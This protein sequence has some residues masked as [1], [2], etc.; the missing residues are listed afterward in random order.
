VLFD[1]GHPAH[2]H[3]FK[4]F[5]GWLQCHKHKVGIGIQKKDVLACLLEH[6]GYKYSV[7][8]VPRERRS[9]WDLFSQWLEHTKAL[10]ALAKEFRPNLLVGTSVAINW[11]G[12]KHKAGSWN[13]QEDDARVIKDY[14]A[15]ASPFVT[16]K[17]KPACL[18]F[19]KGPHDVYHPSYHELAY[20]HPGNFSPDKNILV[21]YGLREKEYVVV[22]FCALRAHH[23][24]Q[25]QGISGALR[26][27]IIKMMGCYTIV[28][29]VENGK[30]HRIEPWDMHH[31][32]AYAKM[33]IADSQ[34][35]TIEGA[36]LGVP[37]VRINT[38]IGKSTV[39]S[40][41]EDTYQLAI[42]ILPSEDDK[43]IEKIEELLNDGS[44]AAKWKT[45]RAR[46]LSEKV[47]LN[48]WMIDFFNG[49]TD[50]TSAHHRS[51]GE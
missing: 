10:H 28:E 3:L 46:L 27:K 8:S 24:R 48:Q 38:F 18:S 37:S 1:L 23:D 30:T 20:L 11:V 26:Q 19:E 36:V 33:I 12:R 35:M 25:A 47:D 6:A 21:K 17:I 51:A 16:Y 29:S 45:R 4:N 9:R 49:H 32:L 31:V 13:F 5:I 41:L 2:F 14:W 22:R 39:I 50:G 34:T 44:V 43:V 7:L 40:E 15:L 42:G